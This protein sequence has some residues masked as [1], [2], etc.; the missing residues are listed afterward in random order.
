MNAIGTI[1]PKSE[2]ILPKH[3]K[4]GGE[5]DIIFNDSDRYR[6]RPE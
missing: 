4:C 2:D 6:A 1:R 5:Y 3:L